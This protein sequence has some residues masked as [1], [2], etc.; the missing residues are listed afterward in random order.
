MPAFLDSVM[1]VLWAQTQVKA[2]QRNALYLVNGFGP[3]LQALM[4][5]LDASALLVVY[6][7]S[8]SALKAALSHPDA[9]AI[10]QDGRLLLFAGEVSS[11]DFEA[12]LR[13]PLARIGEVLPLRFSP[14]WQLF[15]K[16]YEAFYEEFARQFKVAQLLHR[17]NFND[18]LAWQAASLANLPAHCQAPDVQALRNLFADVP[19]ILVG[20]GPSLDEAG[21]FL[22]AVQDRAL[23]IAV[24][25]SYRAVR[26]LGLRPH[27]VLAADPREST[28]SAFYGQPTDGVFLVAPFIVQPQVASLFQDHAFSW[29]GEN[30]AL[31]QLLRQRLG[32]TKGT[33]LL[34][35]GTISVSVADLVAYMGVKKFFLVGQ[36]MAIRPDGTTHTLNSFYNG[37]KVEGELFD[38]NVRFVAG[39]TSEKVPTLGNLFVYLKT[40]EQWVEAHPQVE[41]SNTARLGAKI[42]KVPYLT[43]KEALS[44]IPTAK[45]PLRK[46]LKA[47]FEDS[48]ERALSFP[49][50]REALKPTAIFARQLYDK[51]LASALAIEGLPARYFQ[52]AYRERHEIR[53]IEAAA[54]EINRL[55][56]KNPHDYMVLMEGRL[57]KKLLDFQMLS[58]TIDAENPFAEELMKNKEFYWA[59]AEGIEPT[60]SLMEDMLAEAV[61]VQA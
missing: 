6:E 50:W 39:N 41:L 34:E 48:A 33:T 51:A 3:Q 10:L 22:K 30:N 61:V 21:E 49:Q 55:I 45:P 18:S 24:H 2:P 15:P 28:Y 37:Y 26:K 25:S 43:Y 29:G 12:L 53:E 59:L 32:L 52:P 9:P 7:A 11:N 31:L 40:F 58:G 5:R 54:D 14:A 13:A 4:A 27:L 47:A 19:A 42:S 60:L 56:D 36:D 16:E 35:K 17:A 8:A 57:K 20:A 1:S 44:K 23:I 38:K 46:R